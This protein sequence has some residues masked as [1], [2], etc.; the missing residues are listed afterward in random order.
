VQDVEHPIA[1]SIILTKVDLVVRFEEELLS[2]F[3]NLIDVINASEWVLGAFVPI[4]CGIKSANVPMPLLFTLHAAVI[5]KAAAAAAF[6]KENYNQALAWME[7]SQGISGFMR[8]VG[9]KWNG[10]PTDRQMAE[11]QMNE[12]FENY[13]QFEAIRKPAEALVKYVEKLPL[14]STDK[15]TRRYLEELSVIKLGIGLSQSRSDS[16]YKIHSDPFDAFS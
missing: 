12:A 6:S 10:N 11:R 15:S 16:L 14:I 7:K 3:K 13:Q 9:D 4:S 8:W 5:L 1:L 2:P